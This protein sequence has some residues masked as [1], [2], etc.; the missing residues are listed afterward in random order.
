MKLESNFGRIYTLVTIRESDSLSVALPTILVHLMEVRKHSSSNGW[1]SLRQNV[2]F[3][4]LI[5]FQR[6]DILLET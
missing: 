6:L 4:R 2:A 5:W 1:I 3:P